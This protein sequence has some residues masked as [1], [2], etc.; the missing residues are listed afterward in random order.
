MKETSD[1]LNTV[2]ANV[3]QGIVAIDENKR[4]IFANKSIVDIFGASENLDGK[5]FIYLIDDLALCEKISRHLERITRPSTAT[6][7]KIFR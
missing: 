5:D 3:S 6:R 4:I 7:A 2:L 1:K